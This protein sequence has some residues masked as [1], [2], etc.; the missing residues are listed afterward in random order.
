MPARDPVFVR[1]EH[2]YR[3]CEDVDIDCGHPYGKCRHPCTGCG[4]G[5]W[6]SAATT[7]GHQVIGVDDLAALLR[8]EF[9]G[10]AADELR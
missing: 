2:A 5:G 1:A 6:A 4:H 9:V 3:K 7:H 10:G 8:R